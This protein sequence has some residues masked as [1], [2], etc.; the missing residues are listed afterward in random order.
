M[1]K[2][3][4][5]TSSSK[6]AVGLLRRITTTLGGSTTTSLRSRLGPSRL[7]LDAGPVVT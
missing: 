7:T 4:M 6:T 1:M 2:S 3:R 5:A